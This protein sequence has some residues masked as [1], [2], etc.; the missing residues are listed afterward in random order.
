[1]TNTISRRRLLCQSVLAL[2]LYAQKKRPNFL[3]IAVDDLRPELGCYGVRG[4]KSPHIDRLA[5]QGMVFE[6]A[7]CQQ[8]VCSPSRTSVMTGARPDSTKVWDLVTHF[9]AAMP[10]VVTLT[11]HFKENGYFVQGIG[12]I[13]HPGYDDKP[14]WST[15]WQT[16]NAPTYANNTSAPE[17]DEDKPKQKDGPAFEA[18]DV[19]DNFYKDGKVAELAA[20]ALRTLKNKSE[21]FF[22]DRKSVV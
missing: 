9:R 19:A 21:P 17:S 15:P 4:I 3:F 18:G 8:A 6:R 11:Q 2:P 7:Y 13:F 22:L 10:N 14:S 20:G 16:P 1:M 12:K 5:K